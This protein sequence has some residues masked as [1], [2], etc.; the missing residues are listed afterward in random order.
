[1]RGAVVPLL[2]LGVC[3]AGHLLV[4]VLLAAGPAALVG[5]ATGAAPA[6]VVVAVLG[7]LAAAWFHRRRGAHPAPVADA[8]RT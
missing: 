8:E 3:C 4:P 5:H 1:V 6:A 2:A 7:A